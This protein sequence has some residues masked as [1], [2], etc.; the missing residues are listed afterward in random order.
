MNKLFRSFLTIAAL[1]TSLFFT[2]CSSDDP[3]PEVP[4]EEFDG[5]K[6]HFIE[7]EVEPHGDHNHYHQ[8]TDTVKVTVA[9]D[10]TVSPH[11]VHLEE[12]AH[13]RLF[14]DVQR[15][16]KSLNQ[17]FIDAGDEHQFFFIPSKPD[18]LAYTYEDKDVNGRGIGLKGRFEVL[19]ADDG[20]FDL[21][22]VLRHGLDKAHAAAAQWN[23]PDYRF[24]GGSDDLNVTF[25]IHP[26]GHDH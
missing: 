13:Y 9:K 3:E 6:F 21:K 5:V 18:Y 23:N 22:V 16:G 11:H 4:Q 25:E 2:A 14:I 12:H 15:N 1:G 17:E 7:L 24:A 26:S 8:T 19:K 20:S 10:G